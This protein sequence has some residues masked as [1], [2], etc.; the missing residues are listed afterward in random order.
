MSR[1]VVVLLICHDH[2]YAHL[3]NTI[4]PTFLTEFPKYIM[5]AIS[6]PSHPPSFDYPDSIHTQLHVTVS[7]HNYMSSCSSSCNILI[8]TPYNILCLLEYL[9]SHQSRPL[10]QGLKPC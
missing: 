5:S 2:K 8:P 9:Q 6:L 4:Q 1:I 7:I 10:H 3:I